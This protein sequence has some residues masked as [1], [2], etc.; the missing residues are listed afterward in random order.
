MKK[1]YIRTKYA[2]Y[3]AN[4]SMSVVGNLSPL[5][6]LTFRSLYGISFSMLGA[7]ILI[8]FCTQLGVDLL[9]SFYSHKFN[10]EKAVKLT[11]VLTSLGLLIYAVFPFFFP[12][13]VYVGLVIGTVVFAA[14]GGLVEVLISPVIA[15]MA[16]DDADHEVS[17]LHS[18]YAWGVVGVVIL[19]TLFLL[20]FGKENWQILALL[21]TIIPIV[22]CVL[23][24][25]SK[26][27]NLKTPQH[28]SN[29]LSLIKGK[30]FLVCFFCIF[31]GGASECTMSQ[32][33]SSYLEQALGIPK[34]WGDVFGV[35][36]FAVML[37]LGRS[38]Y[39][40]YGKNIYK[41]LMLSGIGATLC[42]LAATLSNVALV[43]LIAC[44]MTGFCVAMLWP[45]SLLVASERF[46]A[47]GVA[48]FALMA[49]GGDLGASIGPQLVGAVTDFALKNEWVTALAASMQMSVD[50]LGMKIGLLCA[51]IFPLLASVLLIVLYRSSKKRTHSN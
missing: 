51:I 10:I 14:S 28:A 30:D 3:T 35:A 40:K 37:G 12:D 8:N 22:S 4:L 16:P 45:G 2:C 46:P 39:A 19:S 29:V 1:E 13:A 48:V 5:L 38:L 34:V 7:L 49:A 33:S 11:P 15:E 26:V 18:V 20:V 43:G 32:W 9:F 44:A 27:P 41:V 17:K 31:L 36:L 47:S 23:F 24:F 21:W 6:F 42:Y 50:Q 25:T